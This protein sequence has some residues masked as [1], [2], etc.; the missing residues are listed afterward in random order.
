MDTL[1]ARGAVVGGGDGADGSGRDK[2]TGEETA[3]SARLPLIATCNLAVLAHRPS[4]KS[5][6]SPLL[7]LLGIAPRFVARLRQVCAA[8]GDVGGADACR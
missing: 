3:L 6:G 4:V 8:Q 5:R 2:G 7:P 1:V